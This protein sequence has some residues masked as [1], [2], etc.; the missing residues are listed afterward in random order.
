MPKVRNIERPRADAAG[1]LRKAEQ[2]CTAATTAL[3]AGQYDAA[4]LDAVHA[5][6]SSAD[7]VCVGLG[8]RRSADPDHMRAA[9]LL[10]TVGANSPPIKEKAQV[11]RSLIQLKSRVEYEDKPATRVDAE[12]AAKRC[13]R[14]VSWAKEELVRARLM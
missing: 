3:A 14:L 13:E 10:E 1:Y 12:T 6:I 5:G 8:G 7:A 9:D 4:M 11:L 2:F